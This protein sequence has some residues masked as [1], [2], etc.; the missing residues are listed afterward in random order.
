MAKKTPRVLVA[1]LREQTQAIRQDAR[2]EN[3]P[4]DYYDARI[5]ALL[6]AERVLSEKGYG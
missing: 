1:E 2:K 4:T 6:W 3:K 5:D